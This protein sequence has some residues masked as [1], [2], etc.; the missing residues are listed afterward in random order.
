MKNNNNS[1]DNADFQISIKVIIKDKNNRTLLLKNPKYS[2]MAGFYDLPGGRIQE[3]EKDFCFLKSIKRELRE[4]LG[5][6][7]SYKIKEIPVA[8]S[9]HHFISKSKNKKQ[10]IFLVFFEAEYKG[11]EIIISDEHEDYAWVKLTKRNYKKYFVKGFLEGLTNYLT[12]KLVE[13]K[14]T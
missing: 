11:G 1:S 7:I 5:D 9:R 6:K 2:T 10:Y 14:N 3:N 4:E 8:I 12:H 13:P